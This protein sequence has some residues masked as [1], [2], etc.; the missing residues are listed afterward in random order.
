MGSTAQRLQREREHWRPRDG[1]GAIPLSSLFEVYNNSFIL[2]SP[3]SRI[4]AG[5]LRGGTSLW[6]NNA[7]SGNVIWDPVTAVVYR[8]CPPNSSGWANCDGTHWGVTA[9]KGN[10]LSTSGHYFFCSNNKETQ[11]RTDR[12]CTGA[13]AC[14]AF[15][16]GEGSGGYPC[17]DQ[18]GLGPGQISQ[19]IYVWNNSCLLNGGGCV[20]GQQQVQSYSLGNSCGFGINNYLLENRDFYNY[21]TSGCSGT[22]STGVCEGPLT[23]RASNCTTGVAYFATDVGPQGTLYQ[24]SSTNT[25]R[26]YYTP[27]TYPHP[28]QGPN[29]SLRLNPTHE[30]AG[31]EFTFPDRPTV[32]GVQS[33]K[34]FCPKALS[35]PT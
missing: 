3:Q 12:D 21:K 22:Q 15:L 14:T 32:Y 1:L 25:W 8:A 35:S 13:G 34:A 9:L 7:Y 16:D 11:C 4:R 5:T 6:F 19:P 2:D 20:S 17:R 26:S 29:T 23:A 27:Y 31:S 28:L 24:C 10:V 18:T 33:E 30:A